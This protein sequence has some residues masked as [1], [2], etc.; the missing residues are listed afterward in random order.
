MDTMVLLVGDS[1][2]DEDDGCACSHNLTG[3]RK[4]VQVDGLRLHAGGN[5]LKTVS[6][7]YLF[8]AIL[9]QISKFMGGDI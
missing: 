5:A 6:V 9:Y 4:Q 1:C 3:D 8:R 7:N 2:R